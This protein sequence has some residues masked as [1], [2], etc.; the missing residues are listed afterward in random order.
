MRALEHAASGA[1]PLVRRRHQPQRLAHPRV[2]GRADANHGRAG[3]GGFVAE[4]A[5]AEGEDSYGGCGGAEAADGE[6][7]AAGWEGAADGEGAAPSAGA[8]GFTD[9][10]APTPEGCSWNSTSSCLIMPSSARARSSIASEPVLR[11]R[12]S[13]SSVSLR[14]LSFSFAARCAATCR[15]SAPAASQPPLPNHSGYWGAAISTTKTTASQ[16]KGVSGE[17]EER[18]AAGVA[19][20]VAQVFLDAQ[21]LVVLGDAIGARQRSRLDLPG[22]G[23]HGDV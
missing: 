13:A 14:S 8:A 18:A 20:R 19:R 7:A 1:A 21:E 5:A 2:V 6:G 10:L 15:S 12:T 23:A 9:G 11:S 16:R 22:V 3:G 17:V 4:A